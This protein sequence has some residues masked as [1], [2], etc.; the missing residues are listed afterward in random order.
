MALAPSRQ[1]FQTEEGFALNEVT[2]RGKLCSILPGTTADGEVSATVTPTGV[3]VNV[4]GVLLGDIEDLNFDRHPEY[5]NR[6]VSDV[7]SKVALLNKGVLE[8]D[9]V[10]G[11][12]Q[13]GQDAYLGTNGNASPTQLQDGLGNNA[14]RVGMFLSG[15]NANGFAKLRVDV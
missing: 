9:Q 1:Q 15:T 12:P 7:G 13:A 4:V 6:D 10:S 14:P 5:L 2:E 8:T 11:T 3:G